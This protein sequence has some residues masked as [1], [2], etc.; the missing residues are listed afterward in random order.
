MTLSVPFKNAA[1]PWRRKTL[2]RLVASDDGAELRSFL[3]RHPGAA[4]WIFPWR[5]DP[6]TLLHRALRDECYAAAK[7]LIEHGAPVDTL[8][9][10]GHTLLEQALR[11][12]YGNDPMK[13][14]QKEVA[15]ML[16]TRGAP[17]E[18]RDI[19]NRTV[20]Q[21]ACFAGKPDAVKFLLD[22]GADPHAGGYAHG[23]TLLMDTLSRSGG[24]GEGA[25]LELL[26][27]A[28]VDPNAQTP[29]GLTALFHA[30]WFE[31]VEVLLRHG[32][33]PAHRDNK[34]NSWID[35]L[36]PGAETARVLGFLRLRE[37]EEERRQQAAAA[38]QAKILG[39]EIEEAC[40]AAVPLRVGKPLALR[41]PGA[42]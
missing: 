1:F 18:Q 10:G 7:A 17:L 34:G 26:L 9:P 23:R 15:E 32:A 40:N 5:G 21:S 12:V 2:L 11:T 20:L 4:G 16:L 13:T 41:K 14:E 37:R 30:R 39:D 24:K 35:G 25:L 28:G 42:A 19:D 8:S 22:H 29:S 38:E 6:E 31:A 3:K 27:S 36:T 33:D